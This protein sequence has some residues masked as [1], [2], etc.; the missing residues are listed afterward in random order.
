[1]SY[2]TALDRYF[3][4]YNIRGKEHFLLIDFSC[5]LSSTF[6]SMVYLCFSDAKFSMKADEICLLLEIVCVI[7]EKACT[8]H[9]LQTALKN[10]HNSS[11]LKPVL[12]SIL[13]SDFVV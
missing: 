8:L 9:T 6:R 3:V 4:P 7:L 2:I 10:C 11:L 1:M 12:S 13:K 5:V